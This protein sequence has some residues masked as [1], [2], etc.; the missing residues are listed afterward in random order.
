MQAGL[1]AAAR[2]TAPS[3]EVGPASVCRCGAA[4]HPDRADRCAAGHLI[5]GNTAS[6]VVGHRGADFWH[7][8]DQLRR[9]IR[10]SIIT[11]AGHSQDDA[12][13]GLALAADGIAQASILRDAAYSRL[14]TVGGP[15]TSHGRARRAF[16]VW[17]AAADRVERQ[18]RLVSLRRAPKS[19][20]SATDLI[21]EHDRHREASR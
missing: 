2:D 9:E 11:D 1:Q 16:S 18:L 3:G 14:M 13:R 12:P 4:R 21:E 8:H 7:Q 6:V 17:L 10:D 5:T 15:L 20:P 19:V